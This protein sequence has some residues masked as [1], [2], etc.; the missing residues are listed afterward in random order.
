MTEPGTTRADEPTYGHR[1]FAIGAEQWVARVAGT[2]NA[3]TGSLAKGVLVVVLFH[4]AEDPDRARRFIYLP[5]GRLAG[6]FESELQALFEDAA[7]VEDDVER[8]ATAR[9]PRPRVDGS[10]R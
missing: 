8:E 9:E 2:V 7:L 5:R 10:T 1:P 3:G 4:R 6:L